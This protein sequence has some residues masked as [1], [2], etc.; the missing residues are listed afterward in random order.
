[1][2]SNCTYT[3][4][5]RKQRAPYSKHC[6]SCS[7]SEEKCEYRNVKNTFKN[8]EDFTENQGNFF[9]HFVDG[10]NGKAPRSKQYF[11]VFERKHP[12]FTD[13]LTKRITKMNKTKMRHSSIQ[14]FKETLPNNY[15]FAAYRKMFSLGS[16]DKQI[17]M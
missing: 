4:K 3:G 1:M 9:F 10:E 7:G 17:S 12:N 15:L 11:K 2:K 6:K 16:L 14:E 5:T 8:L 13:V